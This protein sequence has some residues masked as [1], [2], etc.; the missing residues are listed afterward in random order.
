MTPWDRFPLYSKGVDTYRFEYAVFLLNKDI[1]MVRSLASPLSSDTLTEFVAIQ[2]ITQ[3]GLQT[4]DM[5]HTLPNL[6]NLMLTLTSGLEDDADSTQARNQ[7][8]VTHA[9]EGS[10][11]LPSATDADPNTTSASADDASSNGAPTPTNGNT[12]R[13][14]FF[15]PINISGFWQLRGGSGFSTLRSTNGPSAA[16]SLPSTPELTTPEDSGSSDITSSPASGTDATSNSEL[17]A[18]IVPAAESGP[19]DVDQD[20]TASRM[21]R[22]GDAPI[23]DSNTT[24]SASSAA[25]EEETDDT[26]TIKDGT[27]GRASHSPSHSRS[28]SQQSSGWL[29]KAFFGQQIDRERDL[30][31]KGMNSASAGFPNGKRGRRGAAAAITIGPGGGSGVPPPGTAP[32]NQSSGDVANGGV[33]SETT[34]TAR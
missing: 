27:T 25:T 9:D 31:E 10:S 11:P 22:N 12:P 1:E 20:S 33:G 18:D 19:Q 7:E 34:A 4:L 21:N 5:R 14:A 28:H 30:R 29:T 2:L 3:Q 6:K 8:T 26:E 32:P 16:P 13:K 23:V 17:E 15:A 24:V